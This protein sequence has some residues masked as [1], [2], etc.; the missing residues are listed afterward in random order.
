MCLYTQERDL[1]IAIQRFKR[2]KEK[3]K[4]HKKIYKAMLPLLDDVE[5]FMESAQRKID[6]E[7]KP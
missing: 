3:L 4:E 2:H 6:K 7:L 5:L 1:E